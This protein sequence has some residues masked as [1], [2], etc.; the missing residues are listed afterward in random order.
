MCCFCAQ[1]NN[2][3]IMY[4]L[5]W[6]FLSLFQVKFVKAS[7][8]TGGDKGPSP[9]KKNKGK[10]GISFVKSTDKYSTFDNPT[11]SADNNKPSTSHDVVIP[12]VNDKCS[13]FY[14]LASCLRDILQQDMNRFKEDYLQM[15]TIACLHKS[16]VDNRYR[17]S[18]TS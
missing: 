1:V 17:V 4:M 8:G 18:E 16:K 9:A 15:V 12:N 5:T 14:R 13:Q 7:E 3:C 11:N 2:V 6:N 10:S